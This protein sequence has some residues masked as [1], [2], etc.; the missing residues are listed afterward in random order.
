MAGKSSMWWRESYKEKEDAILC[1]T[2]PRTHRI[3]A[4]LVFLDERTGRKEWGA[5]REEWREKTNKVH[6]LAGPQ[7]LILESF[8]VFTWPREERTKYDDANATV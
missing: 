7:Y 2:Q 1:T 8:F 6:Q 5:R 4:V 3:I